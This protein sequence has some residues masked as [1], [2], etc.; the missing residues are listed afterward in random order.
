MAAGIP[1]RQQGTEHVLPHPD[2]AIWHPKSPFV[3]TGHRWIPTPAVIK[4]ALTEY[5][6][7]VRAFDDG[8]DA[9]RSFYVCGIKEGA[10][11]PGGSK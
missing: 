11:E 2:C 10:G 9:M 5:G 6:C 4:D 1:L 8:P 3:G 7:P